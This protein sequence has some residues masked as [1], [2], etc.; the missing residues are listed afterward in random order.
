MDFKSQAEATAAM[1]YI[2]TSYTDVPFDLTTKVK[3]SNQLKHQAEDAAV[4]FSGQRFGSRLR[5]LVSQQHYPV[6]IA[7]SFEECALTA[8]E[9][10]RS[11]RNFFALHM[12]T[13]THAPRICARVVDPRLTLAALTGGL[14]AAHKIID[15]PAYD[16]AIPAAVPNEL[17][18]AH[19]Y[20]YVYSCQQE[21][22]EYQDRRH[23]QEIKGFRQKGLIPP[24]AGKELSETG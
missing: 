21:Y 10:Y 1:A 6:G 22:K 2:I 23:L 20:K 16:A 7:D 8:L 17:D 4:K 15:S 19:I 9:V 24:W 12:V 11:S 13:A 3:L 14:L 5:Q 18:S